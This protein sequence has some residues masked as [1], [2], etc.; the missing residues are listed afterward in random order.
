MYPISPSKKLFNFCLVSKIF[1]WIIK[2]SFIIFCYRKSWPKFYVGI[3]GWVFTSASKDCICKNSPS[4]HKIRQRLLVPRWPYHAEW[5]T[6]PDPCNGPEMI[7][8]WE[9][10][11]IC[12]IT[13]DTRCPV[14]TRKVCITSTARSDLK[15]WPLRHLFGP[16][17]DERQMGRHQGNM[18]DVKTFSIL[19]TLG[20]PMWLLPSEQT[21]CYAKADPAF[22]L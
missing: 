13:F 19:A 21:Y 8:D 22:L 17:R 5:T 1:L 3:C 2:N 16:K 20:K 6:N 15:R 12:L 9:V 4:N 11:E 7:L 14:L 10:I 18:E